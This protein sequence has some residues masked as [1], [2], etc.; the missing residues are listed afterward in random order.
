MRA[1]NSGN[2]LQR[3]A[4]EV[5]VGADDVDEG[6]GTPSD[7]KTCYSQRASKVIAVL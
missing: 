2:A 6:R 5:I 4:F 1:S 3:R 7:L